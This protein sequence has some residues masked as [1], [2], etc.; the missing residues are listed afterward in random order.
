[1]KSYI[2]GVIVL[3]THLLLRFPTSPDIDNA[4]SE[5][6]GIISLEI[7]EKSG[8]LDRRTKNISLEGTIN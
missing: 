2:T 8:N 4:R 3:K 1:M 5:S 6:I 7:G